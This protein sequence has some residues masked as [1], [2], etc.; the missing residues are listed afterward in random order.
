MSTASQSGS[1]VGNAFREET[2]NGKEYIVAPVVAHQEGVYLYP[3]ENGRGIKREFLPG[4]ELHN[5]ADDWDGMPL[6]L[7]H[8]GDGE[9]NFGL[10]SHT[11]MSAPIVGLFRNI[12]TADKKLGGGAWIE[13][14]QI[15]EHDGHL[16]DYIAEVERTGKAEVS[17]GYN[18]STDFN[19]G[20]YNNT[21]YTYVQRNI[22]PDHLALLI[23]EKGNC[24][25]EDGCGLGA[26]ANISFASG[27]AR[28]NH[29]TYLNVLSQARTPDFDGAEDSSWGDVPAD[30]LSHYQDNLNVEDSQWSD[31]PS[32]DRNLIA[33]HTLLGDPD[34]DSTDEGIFF[35][36]VNASTGN[37]N[38]GALEAVRG[39]RGQSANIPDDVYASAYR[40][41]G[42][43]LNDNW[44]ETDVEVSLNELPEFEEVTNLGKHSGTYLMASDEGTREKNNVSDALLQS[45][46]EIRERANNILGISPEEPN[47]DSDGVDDDGGD[48]NSSKQNE[49]DGVQGRRYTNPEGDNGNEQGSTMKDED[50]DDLIKEIVNSS[51]IK[52]ESLEGMGDTCL[53]TTHESVV[54]NDSSGDDDDDDDDDSD[55]T[56]ASNDDDDSSD[57]EETLNSAVE[58]IQ[59]TVSDGFDELRGEIES[60]RTEV[61]AA[62]RGIDPEEVDKTLEEETSL[63]ED[64]ITNMSLTDKE[65]LIDDMGLSEDEGSTVNM[66]G[67]G[68]ERTYE[69]QNSEGDS[70]SDIPVPG[71]GPQTSESD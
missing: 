47:G 68:G 63:S 6:T 69:Y 29:R 60:L 45:V 24:S 32:E 2:F 36:V 23:N 11:N 54:N 39:G 27:G 16:E 18:A 70:S 19:R 58:E 61:D 9:G 10:L 22:Q 4:E 34:A 40:K 33:S 15:G 48:K 62:Q 51:N 38:R 42:E 44:E 53:E 30:T 56:N 20:E 71:S 1:Q 66:A 26:K 7:N 67:I 49:E 35:P 17:T 52:R 14:E 43:L 64:T 31:L 55:V 13:K 57:D 46:Y 50:R 28:A 12:I 65:A 37:L 59:S 41:A 5:T 21:Q 25:V 8:P 3:R